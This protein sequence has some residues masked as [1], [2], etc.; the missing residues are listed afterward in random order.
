MKVIHDIEGDSNKVK[1]TLFKIKQNNLEVM[2]YIK[3]VKYPKA[4]VGKY[5]YAVR[6]VPSREGK[7]YVRIQLSVAHGVIW[8][9]CYTTLRVRFMKKG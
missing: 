5:V 4:E 9:E 2:E 3:G 1:I 6:E 8:E 7:Q